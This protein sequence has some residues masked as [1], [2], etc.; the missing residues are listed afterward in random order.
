M[1]CFCHRG[2]EVAIDFCEYDARHLRVSTSGTSAPLIDLIFGY[3]RGP[4]AVK[5]HNVFYYLTYAGAVDLDNIDDPDRA[6][7]RRCR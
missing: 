7:Q 2:P 6:A 3:K 4:A 5:A 1:M